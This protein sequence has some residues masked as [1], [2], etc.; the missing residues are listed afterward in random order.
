MLLPAGN[1]MP[2][3]LTLS[4]YEFGSRCRIADAHC[5]CVISYRYP[6]PPTA[7]KGMSPH[8]APALAPFRHL[9]GKVPRAAFRCLELPRMDSLTRLHLQLCDQ[10]RDHIRF[11]PFLHSLRKAVGEGAE[12]L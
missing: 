5:H 1:D 11:K 7:Y 12:K 4:G 8:I 2:D 6:A 10:W 3:H 9:V